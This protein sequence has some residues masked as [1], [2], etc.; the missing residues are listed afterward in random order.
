[1]VTSVVSNTSHPVDGSQH[2]WYVRSPFKF[3]F[4]LKSRIRVL[5]EDLLNL[6]LCKFLDLE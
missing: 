4:R 1:M 6:D 2:V 3:E 5:V